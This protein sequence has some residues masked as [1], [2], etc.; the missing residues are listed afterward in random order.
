MAGAFVVGVLRSCR[1]LLSCGV[2][3]CCLSVALVCLWSVSCLCLVCVCCSCLGGGLC[4]CLSSVAVGCCCG[5]VCCDVMLSWVSTALVWV[6]IALVLLQAMPPC[7]FMLHPH[8]M[9]PYYINLYLS[10]YVCGVCVC[11]CVC[12]CEC[13]V[14][15]GGKQI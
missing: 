14:G 15:V 8:R 4:S 9:H 2:L 7:T 12:V 6:S 13:G 10:V 5:V 3:S 11:V 1:V